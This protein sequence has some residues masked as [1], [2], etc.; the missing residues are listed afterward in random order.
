MVKSAFLA[1][2]NKAERLL[3]ED[4]S[5]QN[6]TGI[7]PSTESDPVSLEGELLSRKG[8]SSGHVSLLWKRRFVI[9]DLM[10]GGSIAVYKD[11]PEHLPKG[12]ARS[13]TVLRTVYSKLHRSLS[14]TPQAGW[15]SK[16]TEDD[17]YL[18]FPAHVPWVVKDQD[19]D[20]STFVI[21]IPTGKDSGLQLSDTSD[22]SYS[23]AVPPIPE[24]D[25]EENME[26]GQGHLTT[27]HSGEE[28]ISGPELTDDLRAELR[29]ARKRG[30]PL[31]VYFRCN[32]SGSEKGL[33]LRAFARIN[34]LSTEIRTKRSLLVSLTSPLHMGQN[35]VRIR[36]TSGRDFARETR[37][38]ELNDSLVETESLGLAFSNDVEELV[39]GHGSS[40]RLKDKEFRVLPSYAYPH[41]WMNRSEMLEEMVLPSTDFHD[42]RVPGCNQK[43]I[44]SLQVE[45]LQCLGLP[46]LDRT[47]D[48][49]AVAYLVCGQY[50]FST[51]VIPN[52]S[53][54]IWLRKS[55]RACTFPLFHAYTR[56][57][58]GVFDD[59]GRRIKDDFAGRVTLDLARLRPGSSYDVTLPLRLST[60]VYSRRCRGAIR[61]RFTLNWKSER[62]ALLSYI[63]KSLNIPLP[64]HSKADNSTTVLCADP[65]SFRN[66]AITVHGA[67]LPGR[68]TFPQM[69]ATIR[70]FNFTRKYMFTALRQHLRE[71]RLWMY[72]SLSAFVFLTWMH[73]VYANAF[74]LVPA[75]LVVYLLLL[76]MRSYVKNGIDAPGQRGFVPPSWEEMFMALLRDSPEQ[77]SIEPLDF[78]LRPLPLSRRRTS[79]TADGNA[80]VDAEMLDYRIATHEPRGKGLFKMLGF[81]PERYVD[82]MRVEEDHREFPFA[83]GSDYP[84]F[85]VKECLV[86]RKGDHG[87]KDAADNRASDL[88]S[89]ASTVDQRYPHLPRFPDVEMPDIMRKDSSGMKDRDDEEENNF[90]TRRAVMAKG[91]KAAG[92]LGKFT[93]GFGEVTGLNHVVSPIASGIA[94]GMNQVSSGVNQVTNTMSSGMHHLAPSKDP[95]IEQERTAPL[96]DVRYEIRR[97]NSSDS[98]ITDIHSV[99][100][101]ADLM[102]S[103][104]LAT[105]YGFSRP[106][107]DNGEDDET[108]DPNLLYPEQNI[109][110]DGPSSGKKLTDEFTD[111]KD[112][113]HDLTWH[114]FD[115]KTYVMKNKNSLFFGQGKRPEKR[116]KAMDV[117]QKL[118]KLLHVG[119]YSHSNPFIARLGL[120]GEPIIS[121]VY[122]FL[123][124][125]RA[126]FNVCTWRDPMLT[127]WVS[128]FGVILAVILFVFPWRIFLFLLG[129]GLVGPQN[130]VIRVLRE[131]GRLPPARVRSMPRDDEEDSKG[132]TELPEDQ[133][134]FRCHS[135]Q[136]GNAPENLSD[137][138][139]REVQRIVVP[140]KPLIYQRFYDWP[141]EPQYAQV[142]VDTMDEDRRKTLQA[143]LQHRRTGGREMGRLR[144][145]FHRRT[146]TSVGNNGSLP[147]LNPRR[148]ATTGDWQSSSP[149][150]TASLASSGSWFFKDK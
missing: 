127:F 134:V 49:D 148:R 21:E 124:L 67:H 2:P 63:P 28:V 119:Q 73:A 22:E 86:E 150:A 56:L 80:T 147:P 69:R 61:L 137:I 111:I 141:P 149:S 110:I 90:A 34:R 118:D 103:N 62:E 27:I 46:K 116:R 108:I 17:F 6:S 14:M 96:P 97:S 71:M 44:G 23:N 126:G 55:R 37:Q 78:G 3:E 64:Q 144:R 140:N 38:L 109:D 72:P 128:I 98:D 11:P 15:H 104:S 4:V 12:H 1:D 43:E 25:E 18:L 120:F 29:H 76:L 52:R 33:W 40:R 35:R 92:K 30:K 5:L 19:N 16:S 81:L 31:R 88:D 57:Y 102:P 10:D 95:E 36:S 60:H 87:A 99:A 75:Y 84:K 50:A 143:E 20:D 85:T 101:Y 100:T 131:C 115:D 146:R 114:L 113:M 117:P 74:S 129:I 139:P 42:L 7:P 135:R 9:L 54:P 48:T 70:E 24:D 142:K 26:E 138:D 8:R 89:T 91:K 121:S 79:D 145:R 77:P 83:S 41:R 133:P 45:V 125:F 106:I 105:D 82:C 47:S 51:D 132:D 39:R 122:S 58:V 136:Q 107:G 13:T 93:T 32:K 65:K 59:D 94:T 112:K 68:F 130:W 123:C 66:I 53:N